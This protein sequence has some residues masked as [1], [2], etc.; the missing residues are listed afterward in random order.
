[1]TVSISRYFAISCAALIYASTGGTAD[2]QGPA[3]I[4]S[5]DALSAPSPIFSPYRTPLP[6]L[7]PVSSGPAISAAPSFHAT[8]RSE[9][10]ESDASVSIDIAKGMALGKFFFDPIKD[11]I[12]QSLEREGYTDMSSALGSDILD[13]AFKWKT[14]GV[15]FGDWAGAGAGLPMFAEWV[16]PC[17]GIVI[18]MLTCSD[19]QTP[20][21]DDPN[22]MWN[23]IYG[24]I[25]YSPNGQYV[26]VNTV[27]PTPVD[28]GDNSQPTC[29]AT[30][31]QQW[32]QC[33]KDLQCYCD[34]I[35]QYYIGCCELDNSCCDSD[36]P[37]CVSVLLRK[38]PK[39]SLKKLTLRQLLSTPRLRKGAPGPEIVKPAVK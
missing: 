21:M 3:N 9:E 38:K 18:S 26:P 19:T 25:D 2:A 10:Y 22:S 31:Q 16:A 6:V 37:S 15:D 29:D 7:A 34:Y 32:A 24:G 27:T 36:D 13:F 8:A 11:S 33:S 1:M 35:D 14:V 20:E 39:L 28:N 12:Q 4:P 17:V 30:C 5:I 23:T